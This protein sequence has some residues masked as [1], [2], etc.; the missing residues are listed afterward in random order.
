MKIDQ[1]NL[2]DLRVA[3][4]RRV[5]PYGL[6]VGQAFCK[7]VSWAGKHQL[8]NC[9]SLVI[10]AYWDCPEITPPEQCRMDACLTLSPEM[11]PLLEEGIVIQTLPGGLCA[12]YLRSVYDNDFHGGWTDFSNWQKQNNV[13]VDSRPWY[14]F[15]YGTAAEHHPLKKWVVDFVMPLKKGFK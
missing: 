12:T 9:Q 14:E 8:F 3:G 1:V 4:V 15:Y 7:L 2:P 5:G 10:G 11:N 13:E 6:E